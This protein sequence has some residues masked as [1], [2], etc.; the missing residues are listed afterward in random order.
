MSLLRLPLN[1]YNED[2]FRHFLPLRMSFDVQFNRHS[3]RNQKDRRTNSNDPLDGAVIT[4]RSTH[5]ISSISILYVLLYS[6]Y[7]GGKKRRSRS[8]QIACG[9]CWQSPILYIFFPKDQTR[10]SEKLFPIF[11][12]TSI[13]IS[14]QLYHIII[15]SCVCVSLSVLYSERVPIRQSMSWK[16]VQT[17][18][19]RAQPVMGSPFV[20]E[21]F[22]SP[23]RDH[24]LMTFRTQR[25]FPSFLNRLSSFGRL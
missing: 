7:K 3:S 4:S 22:S 17:H 21:K 16:I 25:T 5:S 20:P 14:S 9:Q 18:G 15:R 1:C 2:W 11:S 19:E 24:H 13:Y 8:N 23:V 12:N 6:I 10:K